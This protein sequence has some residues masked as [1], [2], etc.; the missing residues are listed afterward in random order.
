M[1]VLDYKKMRLR[2]FVLEDIK[3]EKRNNHYC[4]LN[5]TDFA[6]QCHRQ[7][8]VSK[9]VQAIHSNSSLAHVVMVGHHF[10][11]STTIL[12]RIVLAVLNQKIH[13]IQSISLN[14]IPMPSAFGNIYYLRASRTLSQ[15]CVE[16][17]RI[18]IEVSRK[19]RTCRGLHLGRAVEQYV[20]VHHR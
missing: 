17:I 16:G 15:C 20:N 19:S 18:Q 14:S 9:L 2:P 7:V 5:E 11:N 1:F 8:L 13:T 6:P 4:T 10:S 3:H 12:Q